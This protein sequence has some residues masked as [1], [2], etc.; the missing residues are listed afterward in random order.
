[1]AISQKWSSV[2]PEYYNHCWGGHHCRD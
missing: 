2:L 1:M